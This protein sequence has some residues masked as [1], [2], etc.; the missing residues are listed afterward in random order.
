[1]GGVMLHTF[2]QIPQNF[3]PLFS[4]PPGLT[5][6]GGSVPLTQGGWVSPPPPPGVYQEACPHRRLLSPPR[7]P[8]PPPLLPPRSPPADPIAGSPKQSI[9]SPPPLRSAEY[10][11]SYGVPELFFRTAELWGCSFPPFVRQAGKPP[12]QIKHPLK[13][14]TLPQ[15]YYCLLKGTILR[16]IL[17]C[18]V[19]LQCL[20]FCSGVSQYLF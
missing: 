3:R 9:G 11:I 15:I 7:L 8:L 13:Q 6:G 5:R 17:F 20:F 14:S 2:C 1:M 16:P 4:G 18:S 12:L 19:F 10:T